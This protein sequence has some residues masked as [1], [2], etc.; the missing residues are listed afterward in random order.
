MTEWNKQVLTKVQKQV[1]KDL[2]D[3][4]KSDAKKVGVTLRQPFA[5]IDADGKIILEDRKAMCLSDL[6][7]NN[8]TGNNPVLFQMIVTKDI[9]IRVADEGDV[10]GYTNWAVKSQMCKPYILKHTKKERMQFGIPIALVDVPQNAPLLVSTHVRYMWDTHNSMFNCNIPKI[11]K[12][13]PSLTWAE[14]FVLSVCMTDIS[15]KEI[16]FRL[17]SDTHSA[18]GSSTPFKAVKDYARQCFNHKKMDSKSLNLYSPTRGKG[19]GTMFSSYVDGRDFNRLIQDCL[20]VVK[21]PIMSQ[22]GSCSFN[23]EYL[24]DVV[25]III[26]ELRKTPIG[27]SNRDLSKGVRNASKAKG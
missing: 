27:L 4:W 15:K 11:R 12:M 3:D 20:T 23:S 2:F 26:K 24:K 7:S 10:M 13:F 22:W 16:Y 14:V 6:Y 9:N 8:L 19:I 5:V 1:A 17:T 21:I 25:K 18:F